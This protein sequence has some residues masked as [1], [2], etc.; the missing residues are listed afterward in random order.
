MTTLLEIKAQLVS[1]YKKIEFVLVPLIK[2]IFAMIILSKVSTFMD[3]FDSSGKL[4]ILDRTMIR[5]AMSLV[6]AFVPSTWFVFMMIINICGRLFFYSLEGTIIVF[7]VLGVMYLMFL[8]LFPKQAILAI[9]APYMLSLNLVYVLPLV[10]GLIVGPAAI[11][12][13]SVGVVVY[14]LSTH[15]S[16]LLELKAADL[17][18][19]PTVLIEMYRYFMSVA[20]QDRKMMIMIG[21]FAGVIVATYF[22]SRLE[23]DFIHYIAIGFGGLV[24]IFGFIIGNIILGAG[25]SIGGVFIGTIFGVIIVGVI[26][27]F[28]FSLDYEKTEK[29]QFE[30]DD[31]YYYVRAVPKMK[32]AKSKKEVKTIE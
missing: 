20:T 27:F 12:P 11:I 15:L 21:V 22:V 25:V 7:I 4:A 10:T 8:R 32:I 29:Q 5:M 26:Q 1:M 13:V 9:V 31:Y 19:M 16:G 18:E 14:F 23:M 6:V 28:R 2:F 24:M 17:S 30:D 3:Q